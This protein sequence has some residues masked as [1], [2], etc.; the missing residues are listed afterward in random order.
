MTKRKN[1][2]KIRVLVVY[3]DEVWQN[4]VILFK[5]IRN[6]AALRK[7][8]KELYDKIAAGS[9]E[10]NLEY[11]SLV[12]CLEEPGNPHIWLNERYC[13]ILNDLEVTL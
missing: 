3:E 6:K 9:D 2:S 4:P 13:F 12:G 5:Q 11:E 10:M 1:D 7:Y 8:V